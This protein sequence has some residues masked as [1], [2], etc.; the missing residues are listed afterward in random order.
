VTAVIS[1]V[2]DITKIATIINFIGHRGAD[3]ST[4]L[5]PTNVLDVVTVNSQDCDFGNGFKICGSD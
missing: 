5:P 2:D 4:N 1:R 3:D